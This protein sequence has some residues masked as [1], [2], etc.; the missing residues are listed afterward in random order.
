MSNQEETWFACKSCGVAKTNR[1]DW[2]GLGCGSDY[3]DIR[4]VK[5][6]AQVITQD[7]QHIMEELVKMKMENAKDESTSDWFYGYGYNQA[8][9]DAIE[10][11]KST[12]SK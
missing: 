9:Q 7:R 3:N 5:G 12:L 1:L 4:E 6:V 10:L 8:I 2:C 11:V